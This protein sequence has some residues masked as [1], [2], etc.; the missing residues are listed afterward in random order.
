MRRKI[1]T[2]LFLLANILVVGFLLHSVWPLL[3]LLVLDGRADQISRAELPA[4][5]SESVAGRAQIIPKIIHQ[6]YKSCAPSGND[7]IPSVWR[8]AQQ[9]CINLH[10]DYEYKVSSCFSSPRA[11][12]C[13]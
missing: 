1:T 11:R 6:T 3:A 10:P 13:R 9:S 4:P 2:A 7:S 5:N 8:E 12:R